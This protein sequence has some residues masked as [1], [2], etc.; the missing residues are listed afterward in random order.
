MTSQKTCQS[1]NKLNDLSEE[2]NMKKRSI[3]LAVLLCCGLSLI[4][5]RPGQSK[6]SN[7]SSIDSGVSTKANTEVHYAKGFWL[8]DKP[9]YKL[10]HIK[11]PQSKHSTEYTFA[12]RQ[13]GSSPAI[14]DHT[15][16]IDLPVHRLICM[17]SLQL[18]NFIRLEATEKVVGISSTRFLSNPA[19]QEQLANGKTKKIGIEGNFDPEIIMSL[20]P[21]LILIS[22]FK[23]GGYDAM[24]EID[25]PL[26]PHLGYKEMTPLGQA[27]WIKF[28]G[29]LIGEEEKA[30]EL[31]AGI[32]NRYNNLKTLTAQVKKRPMVLSGEIHGGTWYAVGGQSFLAQVFQDAGADYFLKDDPRSGGV[33]LD[34]ETV[35]NQADSADYWRILNSYPTA[36]SYEALKAQDERYADFKAF[37][38]KKVIYCNMR[39]KPY[40]ENMP[41]E[42]ELLLSDFIKVFHPDLLP[43]YQPVYYQ[44]LKQ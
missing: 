2:K 25:I 27:E 7:S 31:F 29:L 20:M 15:P 33:N 1:A 23:Q 8:E 11:D 14:A 24:K 38:Q 5:C 17:T 39:E 35:Y 16:V 40:Y 36:Y 37:K 21:D 30:N 43:D 42:P 19:M 3:Y 34:F 13:R 28:V 10:L 44:L 26:V 22:P 32:E 18:S 41:M 4:S 12:L 6:K 9:G